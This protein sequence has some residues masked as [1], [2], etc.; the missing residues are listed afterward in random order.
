K[1]K[2]SLSKGDA[3]SAA[4]SFRRAFELNTRNHAA[5]VGYAEAVFRLG[6]MAGSLKAAITVLQN[7]PDNLKALTIASS[8]AM[9]LRDW[10]TLLDVGEKWRAAYPNDPNAIEKIAFAWFELG[11]ADL[12]RDAYK[13]LV[14]AKPKAADRQTI[15][16]RLCLGAF[17]YE[18]A[19]KA[20]ETAHTVKAPTAD[21]LYALGRAKMFLGALDEAEQLTMSAI[22]KNPNHPLFYPQ[23]VTLRK[24]DIKD[25]VLQKMAALAGNTEHHA[26][27]RASLYLAIGDVF[28]ARREYDKAMDAFHQGNALSSAL[29]EQEGR[30]YSPQSFE[31]QRDRERKVFASLPTQTPVSAGPAKPVFV[32]GM[33]RSGTTLVESILAAHPDV[34]GAGELHSFPTVH[35]AALQWSEANPGVTLSDAPRSTLEEWRETYFAAYPAASRAARMVVD[36]QPLNFRGVGL[37]KALFP[38]AVIIHIRR[39]PVD[40]GFSIYRNDFGKAWPYATSLETIAHFYGEYA[41]IA[42]YWQSSL[43]EDFPLFQYEAMVENF[44]TEARR[45]VGLCGLDWRDECL[46]FHKA[47]R[48]VATFSTTQVREPM[49]ERAISAYGQYG[50]QL[51]PLLRGLRQ[52]QVDLETGALQS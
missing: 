6:D 40:T 35:N 18:G 15:Y 36:K 25:A 13:P 29:F 20:L 45:L 46:A 24:G 16:A 33:P 38:E 41:R 50:K 17:D 8:A 31:R 52:A 48:P 34:Y 19:E 42:D 2:N 23:Y 4:D 10:R 11:R 39:N 43:G 26:E 1:A 3:R 32:V 21:S 47:K 49:R 12:A 7:A 37:I 44:E 14:D 28:H 9:A 30:A 27:H 22:D 51:D 5:L